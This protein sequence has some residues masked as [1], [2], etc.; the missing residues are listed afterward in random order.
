M[1][2]ARA[3][4][5][6]LHKQFAHPTAPKLLELL[7]NSGLLNAALREEVV[8]VTDSCDICCKYKKPVPRPIVS[9]PLATKFN[10][11]I[12]MDLKVYGKCYFLVIVDVATRYCAA[13]VINNKHA[14]TI[15]KGLLICWISIF[16]PP[17]KI[18][19][20]NG[21]E[22]NNSDMRQLGEAF[23]IKILTTAAESPWS[24]GICERTN[25]VIGDA[26]TKILEDS[27]CD[28][29]SA[30][31]WAVSARN[32]LLNNMGYS[33]NQLVFGFNPGIPDNFNS[34]PPAL[35]IPESSTIVRNNLN[36]LHSARQS[37]L[38]L[39]SCEKV[40]R[41]L[42]HNI[43]ESTVYD[44]EN[45]QEVY[46][47]R[48]DSNK[49]HG[50]GVVIGRDGKQILVKHGGVYVRVHSYRLRKLPIELKPSKVTDDTV[51][52][53]ES[54]HE[55]SVINWEDDGEDCDWVPPVLNNNI[56]ESLAETSGIC[57]DVP[58]K[59]DDNR[60]C[61]EDE[62]EPAGNEIIKCQAL[63][64]KVGNRLQCF[65]PESGEVISGKLVSRAGKATGKYKNCFNLQRD[66]DGSVD[67]IDL[68]KVEQLKEIP[69]EQEMLVLYNSSDVALAK[70]KEMENW[71]NNEVYDEV[72]DE[73]QNTI[74]VRWVIT[75]KIKDT[76]VVT[77]A[78]LVARGFE[79]FSNNMR[80]DSPTCS[81]EAIRLAISIALSQ[82]WKCHTIDVK[83]AYLQGNAITRD[84]YLVPPPEY[85]RGNLWK[86]KKTV[87]GL[88]DAARA[89]YLRVKQELLSLGVQICALDP[90]LFSW[91]Y[92]GQ[93]EGVICVYVDDFLWA[94][95]SI[96]QETVIK[97]LHDLFLIGSVSDGSF[98]YVGL[99]IEDMDQ[100]I[101][102]DQ[103]HYIS[104]LK[105][106]QINK[107]RFVGKN[108][109]MADREKTEYRAL[110][111]QLNWVATH[112]RPDIAFDVCELS[113]TFNSAT[114]ADVPRLNKVISRLQSE[115]MKLFFPVIGVLKDCLLECYSDASL[116]NLNGGGSQGGFVIF[117][118]DREGRRCPI[119]WQTKRIRRVVKS[120]LSAE[121]LSLLEGAETSFYLREIIRDVTKCQDIHINCYVD[122]KSLVDCLYSTHCVG[123][124]RLRVDVSVLKDMLER[125]EI[126]S[127][128]WIPTSVQLAN[129]LTKKGASTKSLMDSISGG[130]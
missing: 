53:A 115:S 39:E 58:E 27:Q 16:G 25:A 44:V 88:S 107:Q 87:Y 37:F 20:D 15:I 51:Q 93:F 116:A 1:S 129:C 41:A 95:S 96:F 3:I 19:S 21:C 50:P 63:K 24:N 85:F 14:Y 109:E 10:E 36:A 56:G 9:I 61:S 57:E 62:N 64:F 46:Y 52:S 47:K 6:K 55:R 65:D 78:R 4:A 83:A 112:T 74:S 126:T 12:S 34:S 2:D 84:I 103:M 40:K 35:E 130:Q 69:D 97:R 98:K 90:A 5:L 94:G 127:V 71:I 13:T 59:T 54:Q 114:L 42:R 100:G 18:L 99:N 117:L 72:P 30:L 68:S 89:W 104:T 7:N 113:G 38:K 33:P 28:I 111:G 123:D 86:L 81:K 119:L 125:Q 108:V 32:T 45:G 75:E 43:R 17:K 48:N 105:P 110:L 70:E 121:A 22:F 23:N 118:R 76:S 11:T 91:H 80:K 128:C 124:R 31:A 101:T 82:Q 29:Q 79:E 60:Q 92:H 102:I 122:N 49:W 77:K 106:M 120:T 66:S 67:W 26:V 8:K 73:G